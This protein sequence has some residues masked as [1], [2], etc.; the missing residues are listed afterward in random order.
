MGLQPRHPLFRKLKFCQPLSQYLNETL[1]YATWVYIVYM[2][3]FY[4]YVH[5]RMYI[6][7][8][9]YVHVH[10]HILYIIIYN[11]HVCMYV[12]AYKLMYMYMY[13]RIYVVL[14]MI[15]VHVQDIMFA[16]TPMSHCEHLPTSTPHTLPP[17]TPSA[18]S[19][20][21]AWNT[22]HYLRTCTCTC[23]PCS[24]WVCT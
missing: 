3:T 12:H 14:F 7:S 20:C 4:M 22:S 13:V 5:V 16:V 15:H 21:P 1:H 9:T 10:M 2:H 19:V 24:C 11:V 23:I 18:R 17:H 6:C 8:C